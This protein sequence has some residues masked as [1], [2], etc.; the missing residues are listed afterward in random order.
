MRD[1]I[2]L[3]VSILRSRKWRGMADPERLA[4]VVLF[5]EAAQSSPEGVIEDQ[6]TALWLLQRDGLQVDASTVETLVRIGAL[7]LQED[8]TLHVRGWQSYQ[9]RYRG[10]SDDPALKAAQERERYWRGEAERL[11]GL[12]EAK[13]G[14]SLGGSGIEE[15][16]G[17]GREEKEGRAPA[18]S[19]LLPGEDDPPDSLDR[20]YELTLLRPWGKPSGRWLRE[21]EDNY[22]GAEIVRKMLDS[23]FTRDQN[24][25]DLINRVEA[26]LAREAD[27][28]RTEK[29]KQSRK[30]PDRNGV[31][32]E[33]AARQA[34]ALAGMIGEA[35][36]PPEK[37]SQG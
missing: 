9:K 4:W 14:T 27:R 35:G 28:K 33:V 18:T 31:D 3:Y 32:P 19:T 21:I 36:K 8:G 2:A 24:A 23:E 6:E 29:A 10:P 30:S 1:W 22:G 7:D 12:D 34:A 26:R 17:E 11:R 15:S 25:R 20:F 37:R 5:L 13:P 16:R